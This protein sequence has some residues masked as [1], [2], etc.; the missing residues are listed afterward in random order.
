[1]EH[2]ERDGYRYQIECSGAAEFEVLAKHAAAS[3]DSTIRYPQLAINSNME[4]RQVQP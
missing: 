2:T 4:I 1:M 3:A